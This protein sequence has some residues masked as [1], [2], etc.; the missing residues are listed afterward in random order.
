MVKLTSRLDKN[1]PL[2]KANPM[3]VASKLRH[4]GIQL[5][6][7]IPI[8]Y[9][10]EA[11]RECIEEGKLHGAYKMFHEGKIVPRVRG[12]VRPTTRRVVRARI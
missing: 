10:K 9:I 12:G 3:C 4:K 2:R 6:D 11:S 5:T 7:D 8:E 1:D